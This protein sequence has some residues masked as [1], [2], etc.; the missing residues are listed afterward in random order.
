MRH[1]LAVQQQGEQLLRIGL[2]RIGRQI[3]PA[4]TPRCAGIAE[5]PDKALRLAIRARPAGGQRAETGQAQRKEAT[6]RGNG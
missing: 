4:E 1:R 5:Y 2:G 6:P 3:S